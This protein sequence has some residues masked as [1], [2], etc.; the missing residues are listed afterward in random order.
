M[1]RSF[2]SG[3][4]VIAK[5]ARIWCDEEDINPFEY[6]ERHFQG[7]WG[8]LDDEKIDLQA[9]FVVLGHGTLRSL[10]P[11]VG[12]QVVTTADRSTTRVVLHKDEY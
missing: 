2:L 11:Q 12:L 5:D 7:D 1:A 9:E 10:F 3:K 8:D 4:C 6:L